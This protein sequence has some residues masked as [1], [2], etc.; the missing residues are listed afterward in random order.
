M[1]NKGE[2]HLSR[3]NTES[4]SMK[5][6]KEKSMQGWGIYQFNVGRVPVVRVG[7]E[8]AMKLCHLTEHTEACLSIDHSESEKKLLKISEQNHGPGE[9]RERRMLKTG[10]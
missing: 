8:V 2:E 9:R 4:K 1:G 10:Q 7:D 5:V 6:G 3:G